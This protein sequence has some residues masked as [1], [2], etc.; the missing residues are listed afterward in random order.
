MHFNFSELALVL[1]I[2]VLVIKPNR[3]PDAARTMGRWFAW[4]RQTTKKIKQEMEKP[5]DLFSY[6]EIQKKPQDHHE[7]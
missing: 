1:I 5:L 7:S 6:H 4:M 2:A 3:L